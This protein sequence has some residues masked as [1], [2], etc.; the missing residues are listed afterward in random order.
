M[1][2]LDRRIRDNDYDFPSHAPPSANAQN[3]IQQILTP[4]PS[5]RPTLHEILDHVFFIMGPVPAYI[6]ASAHDAPP[7]FGHIPKAVS[8]A[9]L[10][11]LRRSA[12]LDEDADA[13]PEP[14]VPSGSNSNMSVGSAAGRTIASSI[15]QQEKEF[16][17]AVQP[18][19]PISALLSSARQPLLVSASTTGNV[20]D[21]NDRGADVRDSPL[22][23]RKLQAAQ[24]DS[25]LRRVAKVNADGA[26]DDETRARKK[27]LESQKARIVAQMAP[28][29]EE[30]EDEDGGHSVPEPVAK[31]KG[32]ELTYGIKEKA[33][34]LERRVYSTNQLQ[35]KERENVPPLVQTIGTKLASGSSVRS[36]LGTATSSG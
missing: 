31:P 22:F 7:Y 20:R 5:C 30:D 10:R 18:G 27:E 14:A 33:K 32:D 34:G 4:D 19:S 12:L 1:T 21:R 35:E 3:L 8:D 2:T 26:E 28:V 29:R 15:A 24:R 23:I 17:K 11:R 6:P 16:Q 36:R 25:P 13:E 9:N